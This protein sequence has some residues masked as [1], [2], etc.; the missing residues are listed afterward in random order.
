MLS[1]VSIQTQSLELRACVN[2]NRKK[3]KRLH[4]QAANHS[5]QL[6]LATAST[7]YSYWLALAFVA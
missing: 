7:E 4:W 1:P 6:K 5:C 2:E 3:R